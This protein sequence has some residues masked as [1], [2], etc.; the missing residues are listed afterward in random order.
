MKNMRITIILFWLTLLL[1]SC[2]NRELAN[3]Y[4]TKAYNTSLDGDHASAEKLY[5]EAIESD[6]KNADAYYN[7]G[8]ERHMLG[9][10][11]EAI[12]DYTKAIKLKNKNY[13]DGY[14]NRALSYEA[15]G[16]KQK[17]TDDY[18]KALQLN[19]NHG[20]ALF[21]LGMFLHREGKYQEAVS[22]YERATQ[23]EPG[24]SKIWYYMGSIRYTEEN[25]P[26]ALA[27][28]SKAVH[29]DPANTEALYWK[30]QTYIDLQDLDKAWEVMDLIIKKDPQHALAYEA[31][32]YIH[33]TN[34]NYQQA[35]EDGEKA[36]RL[37]NTTAEVCIYIGSSARILK[38]RA[39]AEEFLDRALQL[40]P[41]SYYA[42]WARGELYYEMRKDD[43]ACRDLRKALELSDNEVH[44]KRLQETIEA[45]CN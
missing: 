32:A 19:P 16:D 18:A 36:I 17:A 1:P 41:G 30:G 12:T 3:L 31:R 33:Y 15:M 45:Y 4:F 43:R 42:Y 6:P 20:N 7:R 14:V 40:D 26:E 11:P 35:I 2:R 9:K 10:Y 13:P 23:V 44:K 25:Y 28:F 37:G 27:H 29:L 38:D 22:Y 39:K 34:G 21:Y 8:Y 5:T 24:N